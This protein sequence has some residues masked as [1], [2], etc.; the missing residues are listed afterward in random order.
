MLRSIC[1]EPCIQE[2]LMRTRN[3]EGD[4]G[5]LKGEVFALGFG[6]SQ[7]LNGVNDINDELQDEL[8]ITIP[9]SGCDPEEADETTITNKPLRLIPRLIKALAIYEDERG[10]KLCNL[11]RIERIY[12]ILG[13]SAWFPNR[14]QIIPGL[15]LNPEEE[16][17]S[18]RDRV[19]DGNESTEIRFNSLITY[20]Q[21]IAAVDRHRSG[22][23]QLPATVP[24]DLSSNE[25]S[26]KK[27]H[28]HME[29]EEWMLRQ[30]DGLLGAW[31]VEMKYKNADGDT[32]DLEFKNLAEM[33]AELMGL[34]L[35]VASDTDILQEL[36]FKAIVETIKAQASAIQAADYAKANSEFLGY[37]G[38]DRSQDLPL[39]ITPGAKSIKDA[40]KESKQKITRFTFDDK[41]D[42]MELLKQILIASEITKSVFFKKWSPGDKFAGDELK[43]MRSQ[44]GLDDDAAWD[45]FLNELRNLEGQRFGTIIPR[46]DIN[47]LASEETDES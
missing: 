37:H 31:P 20:L 17:E 39:S 33:Q 29:W 1:Q 6:L 36:G 38:N 42:L 7:V 45:D 19:Y 26:T 46:P 9:Y 28:T 24:E 3:I 40:L 18:Q 11:E 2:L 8:T 15:R 25:S 4:V 47:N 23:H 14:D 22:H 30:M 43:D 34:I 12:E 35:G 41:T 16:I 32:V 21:G 13:G 44:E 5:A 10:K 27:I